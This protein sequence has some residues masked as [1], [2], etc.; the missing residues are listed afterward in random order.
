MV[1]TS[2]GWHL[3]P[4]VQIGHIKGHGCWYSTATDGLHGDDGWF[5]QVNYS[6]LQQGDLLSSSQIHIATEM[7]ASC[8]KALP[9]ALTN[10]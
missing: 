9:V 3:V 4:A 6:P 8:L 5:V 2:V 10:V 7:W 1:M